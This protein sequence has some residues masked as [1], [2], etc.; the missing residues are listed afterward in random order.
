MSNREILMVALEVLA[1]LWGDG[2]RR[3]CDLK[4][5]F[6]EE[7]AEKIQNAVNRLMGAFQGVNKLCDL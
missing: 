1:G 6:G 3:D 2:F 7:D 5:C 4:F